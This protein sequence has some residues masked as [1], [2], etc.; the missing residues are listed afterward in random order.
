MTKRINK[1]WEN[2]KLEKLLMEVDAPPCYRE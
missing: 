1:S 2:A